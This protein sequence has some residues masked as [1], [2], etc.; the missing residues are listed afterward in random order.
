M[1]VLR[2]DLQFELIPSKLTNNIM[3][4][5]IYQTFYRGSFGMAVAIMLGAIAAHTLKTKL[6]EYNLQ[7]FETAVKYQFYGCLGLIA[8]GLISYVTQKRLVL[9]I[10]FLRLG[11]LIFSGTLYFLALRPLAGIEGLNWVGAIT[12]LGGLFMISAWIWVAVI[13]YKKSKD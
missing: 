9:P 11:V 6:P 2:L 1:V 5:I 7:I 10:L 13:F 4:K 12:P 3:N 8:F